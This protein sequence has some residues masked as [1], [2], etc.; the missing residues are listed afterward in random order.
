MMTEAPGWPCRDAMGRL[1]GEPS[2]L[3]TGEPLTCTT[4][5]DTD[6][7][8]WYLPT[9]CCRCFSAGPHVDQY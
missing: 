8:V 1:M 7:S 2:A 5:V 6:Q 3:A 4:S 9:P